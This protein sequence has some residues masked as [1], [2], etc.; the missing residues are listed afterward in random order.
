MNKYLCLDPDCDHRC[1]LKTTNK[2]VRCIKMIQMAKWVDMKELK[3][4]ECYNTGCGASEIR[5]C[6]MYEDCG[7]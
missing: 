6:E 7:L 2:P 5:S 3:C 1:I 4:E